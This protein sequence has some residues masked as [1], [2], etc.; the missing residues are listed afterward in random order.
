MTTAFRH[1]VEGG[2][3]PECR[4]RPP[5][6]H[7][8]EHSPS[9]A[10]IALWVKHEN[11]NTDIAPNGIKTKAWTDSRRIVYNPSFSKLPFKE[12]AGVVVHEI[13]HVVLMHSQRAMS[14]SRR[15]PNFSPRLFNY[16]ADSIINE[17]I[18]R[19]SW[20]S[21]PEGAIYLSEILKQR[22]EWLKQEG[23]PVPD[24]PAI[25]SWSVEDVYHLLSEWRDECLESLVAV[26]GDLSE[27]TLMDIVP[28][29]GQEKSGDKKSNG[30]D[31]K[32]LRSSRE[33]QQRAEE[34]LARV[35]SH[36][37]Q[38]AMAG[39]RPGG[40]LR[41]IS[42]DLPK[43]TTPWERLLRTQIIRAFAPRSEVDPTRPSR[44][45]VSLRQCGF[46]V[47]YEPRVAYSKPV[48]RI[49]VMVDTSGS[50]SGA[51]LDRV[52]AE[53]VQIVKRTKAEIYVIVCDAEV[54]EVVKIEAGALGDVLRKV[55]FKGGGGTDFRPAFA[56]AEKVKPSIGVYLTDMMG[57]FPSRASFRTVWAVPTMRNEE[58]P[59]AP[60]GKVIALD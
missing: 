6:N 2:I 47:S 52:A 45:W 24:F 54:T 26:V 41:T 38:R 7:V 30:S 35:W 44:R 25:E 1:V 39:D 18:R 49:A 13:M 22:Q 23:K 42:G 4:A 11:G 16:A 29:S 58:P 21:L 43:V 28:S 55:K 8:I 33:A 36:R 9:F 27:D 17:S 3:E 50:M 10:A 48:P 60:F 19:Q 59:Q 31:P 20:L 53:L 34:E 5:L 40:L 56:A 14:L 15:L 51:I 12:Q 57:T 37:L 46:T 32:N